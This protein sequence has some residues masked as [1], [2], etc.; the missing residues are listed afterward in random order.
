M[1]WL[2]TAVVAPGV[3]ALLLWFAAW[4]WMRPTD[5]PRFTLSRE[6]RDRLRAHQRI[7]AGR[8]RRGETI[9]VYMRNHPELDWRLRVGVP[10]EY[11]LLR[12]QC[13]ALDYPS[14]IETPWWAWLAHEARSRELYDVI[15]AHL[16]EQHSSRSLLEVWLLNG[17]R[18]GFSALRHVIARYKEAG[19]GELHCR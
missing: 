2:S 16:P 3:V 14:H 10:F 17:T 7:A 5:A 8:A 12:S 6:D 13:A 11:S 1:L 19:I 4:W 18:D 15:A 9:P